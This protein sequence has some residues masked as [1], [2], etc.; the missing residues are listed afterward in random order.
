[1]MRVIY[2]ARLFDGT[3][4]HDDAALV[5]EGARVTGLVPVASRP[6]MAEQIDCGG[7]GVIAPGL[8]DLQV[9]GGGGVLFNDTPTVEGIAAIAGAH[10]RDGTLHLLPTVITDTPEVL[11]SALAAAREAVV[12]RSGVLGIHVEGPFID[13]ERAGAHHPDLIR[14]MTERDADTLIAARFGVMLVTL[15]P[16]AAPLALIQRLARAGIIVSLGH[17]SITDDEAFA[18]FDAGATSVTHVFNAMSPL[19]HRAPGLV[20]AALARP[21]IITGLI[22]DGHHVAP[23]AL[24]IALAAKGP[25]GVALVSDAMPSAGGGPD[26]FSLQGRAVHRD[27][28]RLAFADGTL[29]GAS[30]TLIDCIRYLVRTLDVPLGDALTMAT[31]TPARLLGL[32]ARIGRFAPGAE[33]GFVHLGHDLQVRAVH[34]PGV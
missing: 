31:A 23:T 29:A 11:G 7:D 6:R 2:G 17:A 26:Q 5:F 30:V 32:S 18:A 28:T 19:N 16:R 14:T 8:I 15:S 25:D 20:G 34:G 21:D 10:R 24:R 13:R 27:G 4:F 33:P 3:R 22:A 9:N 12:T 1:M